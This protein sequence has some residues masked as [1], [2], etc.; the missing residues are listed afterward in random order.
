MQ[1]AHSKSSAL[2][3]VNLKQKQR[4][5]DRQGSSLFGGEFEAPTKSWKHTCR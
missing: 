3:V 5:G 1:G 2:K 4:P